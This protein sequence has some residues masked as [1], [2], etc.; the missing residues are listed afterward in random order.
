MKPKEKPEI[1]KY[2]RIAVCTS[3]KEF[4]SF[5]VNKNNDYMEVTAWDN[6]EGFDVDIASSDFRTFHLT[7][8]Q[9]DAL[10]KLVK[11]L[12]KYY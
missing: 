5:S 2:E 7:F 12:N 4:C 3:L 1:T 9:Y 8:G 11:A 10:K 6:G